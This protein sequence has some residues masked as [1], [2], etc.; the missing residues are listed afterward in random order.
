MQVFV[1]C[2]VINKNVLE[3]FLLITCKEHALSRSTYILSRNDPALSCSLTLSWRRP[4]SYRNQSIDL[5]SKSMD[6]FLYYNGLRHERVKRKRPADAQ[7]LLRLRVPQKAFRLSFFFFSFS[8]SRQCYWT[9]CQ[10]CFCKRLL[11]CSPGS[12]W[13][14][15]DVFH[16]VHQKHLRS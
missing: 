1:F 2:R 8:L 10:I 9:N 11:I 4:I 13:P 12:V 14:R 16:W 15:S 3:W 7:Y 5:L 6:K